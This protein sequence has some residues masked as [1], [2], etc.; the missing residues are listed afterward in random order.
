MGNV[1]PRLLPSSTLACAPSNAML[2]QFS[3]TVETNRD[4]PIA[5]EELNN[6]N[7]QDNKFIPNTERVEKKDKNNNRF[8]KIDKI[9]KDPNDKNN[10][11][12]TMRD[13][14]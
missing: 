6:A 2:K 12:N 1:I 4:Q 14:S 5:N 10:R 3:V 13:T 11:P 9:S 8:D 7:F